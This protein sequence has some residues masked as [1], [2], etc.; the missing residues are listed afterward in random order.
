MGYALSSTA[1]SASV[2][3]VKLPWRAMFGNDVILWIR[4]E[5][6]TV[7]AVVAVIAVVAVVA[8]VAW[9]VLWIK[10]FLRVG[11]DVVLDVVPRSGAPG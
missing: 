4:V 5:R 8:V 9:R 1:S 2:I 7:V 6:S 3:G 11:T 10:A